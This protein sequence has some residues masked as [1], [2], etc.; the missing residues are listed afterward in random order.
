MLVWLRAPRLLRRFQLLLPLLL[1]LRL[2]QQLRLYLL[3]LLHRLHR[4]C[5]RLRLR[6]AT[7]QRLRFPKLA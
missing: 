5:Q 1:Q 2:C 6:L 3:Y 7:F 4:L